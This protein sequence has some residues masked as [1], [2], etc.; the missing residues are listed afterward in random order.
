[1]RNNFPY[2][3][4]PLPLC[5]VRPDV[6]P[7]LRKDQPWN[8]FLTRGVQYLRNDDVRDHGECCDDTAQGIVGLRPRRC[9]TISK[10]VDIDDSDID[11]EDRVNE[12]S[13]EDS[14]NGAE[15]NDTTQG[16]GDL[17]PP[18]RCKTISKY[19]EIDDSDIDNSSCCNEDSV[20]DKSDEESSKYK[21]E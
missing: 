2:E 15:Y 9:K 1:M 4:S 6:L 11:N 10:Y 8:S 12:E 7:N 19:V 17:H 14:S 5:A 20:N 16:I 13:D 21:C 18:C 3:K